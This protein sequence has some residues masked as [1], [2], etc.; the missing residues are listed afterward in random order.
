MMVVVVQ[1]DLSALIHPHSKHQSIFQH[2]SAGASIQSIGMYGNTDGN[3][4]LA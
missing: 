1:H 3:D 4:M 2:D